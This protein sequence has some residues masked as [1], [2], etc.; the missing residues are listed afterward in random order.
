MSDSVAG[1]GEFGLI[2]AMTRRSSPGEG[3]L[4]GPGDDAAV[5]AAPDGR[6]V[7]T[8]DLLLEQQHFRRDW[9]AAGDVGHKAAAQ[10]LADIAAMGARPTAVTVGLG[11]PPDLPAAWAVEFMDGV[12]AECEPV[13][14]SVVGGD[15]VRADTVVVAVTALGDL[16]GGAPVTRGGARAG[17]VVALCGRLGWAEAGYRVLSRG[18]RTP[19]AVVEAHRRPQVPYDAGPEAARLRASAMC[20]VSDGLLADLG[21]IADA[22]DVLI[23]VDPAA[24]EVPDQLRE[25]AG[26]LGADPLH[27]VLTGGDDNALV[28]TFPP[29]T[30]LPQRWHVIGVV[31]DAGEQPA[32]DDAGAAGRVLVGGAAYT[33]GAG[34]DHFR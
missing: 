33:E 14:C 34:H 4:L 8:T 20:D 9:S 6:V 25:V 2:E 28:A 12:R 31:L 30:P 3:V 26:A 1:L 21:H 10:N 7:V 13:G 32:G 15:V 24:V 11:V 18:F 17:D 23:D 5:T 22:S 29:E 19:R 16:D 27:W